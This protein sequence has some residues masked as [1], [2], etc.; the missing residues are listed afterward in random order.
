MRLLV[1][2]LLAIGARAPY[3][4]Y[5]SSSSTIS[6]YSNLDGQEHSSS[7]ARESYSEQDS[8]GTDRSG[9]GVIRQADG[10][11]IFEATKQCD[12]GECVSTSDSRKHRLPQLKNIRSI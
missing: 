9:D 12:S 4:S 1:A 7:E 5:L 6:S 3:Y 2:P 8:A 10:S 11:Q